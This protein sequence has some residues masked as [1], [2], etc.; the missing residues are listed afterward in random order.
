M[1]KPGHFAYHR[2][3]RSAFGLAIAAS[4]VASASAPAA[5]PPA[6]GPALD[7]ARSLGCEGPSAD[8]ELVVCGERG[9]SPYR[10][11]PTTLE[12]M[13]QQERA[14]NPPRL[15]DRVADG[16]TC[17][18]GP[19]ACPG[20]GGVDFVRPVLLIATA[21]LKAAQGEDWREP[22]R[23]GPDAYQTYLDSKERRDSKPPSVAVS[24]GD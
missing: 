21:A 1:G 24:G 9:P 5:E 7:L 20:E 11:D 19:Q 22:F 4:A 14:A 13:R 23:T 6:A 16:K 15:P 8:D 18:V 2:P 17:A 12:A 10:I 3:M